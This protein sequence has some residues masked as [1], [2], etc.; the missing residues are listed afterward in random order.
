MPE[1]VNID[2]IEE[3]VGIIEELTTSSIEIVEQVTETIE[4]VEG[5][6]GSANSEIIQQIVE[7]TEVT[8]ENAESANIEILE[9]IIEVIESV[10]NGIQGPRGIPGVDGGGGD[11]PT[12]EFPIV[13]P[14]SYVDLA[15]GASVNLDS[16][17]I[18]NAKTG[19]VQQIT[20]SSSVAGKWTI[21]KSSG[22]IDTVLDVIFTGGNS[23]QNPT[24]EWEP[25]H[26]D[27]TSLTGNG[28]NTFYRVTATSLDAYNAANVYATYFIDEVT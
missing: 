2:V 27:Y 13:D 7:I 10:Q 17:I 25:P 20:L 11:V 19:K 6:I 8:E 21:K 16:V 1:E 5:T 15:A 23:G 9:Q 26:R 22:G 14:K 4:I 28:T 24:H 18:D 3:V 12:P